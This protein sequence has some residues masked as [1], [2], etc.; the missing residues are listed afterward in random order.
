MNSKHW[1]PDFNHFLS[2]MVKIIAALLCAMASEKAE[3]TVA[4][5]SF[6]ASGPG[7]MP[8]DFADYIHGNV[9]TSTS[10]NRN[11]SG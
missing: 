9:N 10:I 4:M 5:P 8:R 11:M 6:Q 1:N 3:T 7:N 2:S